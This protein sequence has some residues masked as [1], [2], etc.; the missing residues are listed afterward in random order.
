M[1]VLV[2][3]DLQHPHQTVQSVHAAMDAARHFMSPDLDHPHLCL[4]A[5]KDEEALKKAVLHLAA[6]GI[7][8]RAYAEDDMA[9]QLTS[10]ATEPICG[11]RRLAMRKFQLLK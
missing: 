11:E 4:L 2:R 5:V 1:Y 10:V 6:Q 8:F 3:R 7:R 9:D